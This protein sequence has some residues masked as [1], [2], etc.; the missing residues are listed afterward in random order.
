MSPNLTGRGP[1]IRVAS[2]GGEGPWWFFGSATSFT[3]TEGDYFMLFGE[4]DSYSFDS[5]SGYATVL[6]GSAYLRRII[7]QTSGSMTI[8]PVVEQTLGLHKIAGTVTE[9]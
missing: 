1:R 7:V 3:V 9:T 2:G 5:G 8:T 6:G 4:I